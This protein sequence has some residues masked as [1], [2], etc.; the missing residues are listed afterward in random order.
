[1]SLGGPSFWLETTPETDYPPLT[2]GVSV[3]VAVVG[4]GIT[5][6]TA[7]V[8]LKRAGKSVALL[9]S[10]RIV[11]G[12]SGYTT[13]KVTSGHGASYAKI[14]KAFGE[15]GARTYA[16]ANE[17]GLARIAQF[18][19]EDGIECDF[20]RRP[21]YVYAES[22]QEVAQLRQE[23]EVERKAGLAVSLVDETPLPFSVHA[24]L[25]LENQAQFHPRRYLLALAA[26][27]PGD[28]SHVFEQSR[29]HSVKHGEPCEVTTD[30]GVLRA[31]DVVLATHLPILDRGLF[32]TKAYPHR[33]YAVAAPIG[34]APDPQGMYINSGTPTRSIRTLRDGDRVFVQVGGNG[35]KTGEEEDT[36][37]R[38]DQ[39]VARAYEQGKAIQAG[40]SFQVDDVIDP[41]D[42]RH[43]VARALDSIPP[44]VPR[45][46]KKRPF[47]D[48][49]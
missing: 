19:E 13:A 2:D 17:A 8:L 23:A 34:Q 49:W 3:D 45:E 39:L 37:A 33:S 31:A 41:A 46:G 6:I 18:V 22:E 40:V 27:I 24:A 14:R 10:K 7:A 43:F 42:S 5:G 32:F 21:N 9:D 30:V 16:E 28:D 47:V 20:E 26:A 35:H 48:V 12:A 29:V 44:P 25:R 11:H 36:S 38:Y 1:V 4:A 15:D